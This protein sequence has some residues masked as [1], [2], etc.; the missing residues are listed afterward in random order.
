MNILSPKKIVLLGMMSQMPVAGHVWLVVQYLEGF[1]RLGYDPFY[2]EAHGCTPRELMRSREE[3]GWAHAAA[4]IDGVMRRFGFG[5]RWAYHEVHGRGRCFGLDRGRLQELYREAA[6][7]VNLHGGTVPLPE[8]SATGRLVYLGTDPVFVEVRL[9]EGAADVVALLA[10]HCA[11]FTWG[12]NY[13]NPDCKV[14]SSERFRF[15]PT[16]PPVVA[17]FWESGGPDAR[18]TFTTVGN[19][20]Q[21][22]DVRFRGEV[23]HWSKHH[24]FLKVL[25]LPRRSGQDFELALGRYEESDRELLE[26]HGWQVRQALDFSPD[27]DAYRNYL[28]GSRGE[29]TVAKDQNVRL[30]SGW[31]SERSAQYLAAG[32]P[33]ITQET[34]FSNVLPAG[35]GLLAFSTLEEAVE[36]VG[37][38]NADYECHCRAAAALA[39]ECFNYDVVL[40]RL[41][42]EVGL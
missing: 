20:R 36:A 8:H 39:R 27:L 18:R 34:G 29:F 16:P 40:R 6:L 30:R 23:Y 31:F 10:P 12:L 5:D 24:E 28:Q 1:R 11:F 42:A 21:R 15:R 37:A 38:V 35:R 4:F 17:D 33:V 25:D 14:P 26:A 41:L 32:R 13:G 2:V 19:W 9:Q 3:D 7:L 22:H